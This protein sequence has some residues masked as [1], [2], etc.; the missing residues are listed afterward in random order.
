MTG[1]RFAQLLYRSFDAMVDAVQGDL[2]REGHADLSVAHEFAMQAIDGGAANAAELARALGVTRQAA[3][4]TIA[5]LEALDYVERTSDPADA[6]RKRLV[7]TE[8]GHDAIAIGARGFDSL[9]QRWRDAV[10]RENADAVIEALEAIT[11]P[12]GVRGSSV[13]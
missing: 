9:Y 1:A 8:R 7:V 3:A 4:K 13:G 10:G 5:A 2:A 6:R 11:A 12:N